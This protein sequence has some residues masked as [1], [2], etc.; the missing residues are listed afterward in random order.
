MQEPPDHSQ[1]GKI[2]E[3][4]MK[5]ALAHIDKVNAELAEAKEKA[6]DQELAARDELHRIQREAEAI[7]AAAIEKHRKDYDARI[8]RDVLHEVAEKLLR[9]GHGSEQV[10]Q[11]LDI[12]QDIIDHAWKYLGFEMLEGK[13]ATVQ[14]ESS[15]RS[16]YVYFNWDGAVIRMYYEF[17]GGDTL[18]TIDIPAADKWEKET[19]FPLNNRDSVLTFI[20]K[21]VIRDQAHDHAFEI[22]DNYIRIYK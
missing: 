10:K 6:I 8:R 13:A 22:K 21:R 14:Y 15:G 7:S 3:Q 17:G 2:F 1:A 11:W 16:G 18:A 20:A 12:E 5:D 4:S 19:G 9:A